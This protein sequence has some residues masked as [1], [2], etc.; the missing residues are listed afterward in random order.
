LTEEDRRFHQDIGILYLD[1]ALGEYDVETRVG[2]IEFISAADE[3]AEGAHPFTDLQEH[4]DNY[5][6]QRQKGLH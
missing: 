2:F 3:R 4:F 5:F 6:E 1:H